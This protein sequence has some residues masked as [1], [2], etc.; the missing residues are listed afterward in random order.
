MRLQ[1]FI[2][3]I[4]QSQINKNQNIEASDQEAILN[5]L[6]Q[7]KKSTVWAKDYIY[8]IEKDYR[9]ARTSQIACFLNG[10]GDANI[11]YGDG[12]ENHERLHLKKGKKLFDVI[13]SNP[14]YAIKSFKNYLNIENKNFTLFENLT[15]NSKEIENLFIE[16]TAQLLK[17]RGRAA[18]ILP[19]SILSNDSDLHFATRK[20]LLEYFNIKAIAK[21]GNKTFGATGTNTVILF[22][23]KRNQD[24]ATDR[25]YICY[26]VFHGVTYFYQGYLDRQR[27]LEKFI[28]YRKIDKK[29]YR[30]FMGRA[31]TE[32]MLQ[33]D[34]YRDY[35]NWFDNLTEIKN[36][37]KK[38]SFKN[39]K[40]EE[41]KSELENLFYDKV[42][43]I[44][45]EKF[46]FFMLTLK[47]DFR[48][49]E[50]NGEAYKH[51]QTI[52]IDSGE[53]E[54]A[55][56]FLGYEFS[57]RKGSEGIKINRNKKGHAI[58]K[59]CEEENHNNPQKANS[60]ILK[61]FEKEK[62][63]HIDDAIKEHIKIA[64]LT[65]MLNFEKVALNNAMSLNPKIENE[66]ET[67]WETIRIEDILKKVEGNATKIEQK[68]IKEKGNVPVITQEKD[69][70]FSGYT[71]VKKTITDLPLIIFGDHTCVFKYVDFPFVR[72]ADGTQL[73]KVDD[74][75]LIPKCFYYLS[76]L[77]EITN[78]KN[79]ERHF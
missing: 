47:D 2:E 54:I 57:N 20:I 33:S 55:K 8:G 45:Q 4:E 10:D 66:I 44:E 79:Y 9:L 39:K 36:L 48:K 68:D 60:Y 69:I 7:Y 38:T 52:I 70:L 75:K 22:L 24:F 65:D 43:K 35:Q 32:N 5:N 27:L 61:A 1:H 29:D 12:L 26:D 25:R 62:I 63:N 67:K 18:I 59:M 77:F 41:Q 78:E 56:A 15:E 21:F 34:F 31:A 23:E 72:G 14:P 73:L 13:V 53:K 50:T 40:K 42:L 46:Y 11:I 28:A 30:I 49:K 74:K 76:Q 16:R 17:E 58:N 71:N 51:Q 6:E 3:K 64:K 19:S 37:K